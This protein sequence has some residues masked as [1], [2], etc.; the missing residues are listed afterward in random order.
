MAAPRLAGSGGMLPCEN[1]EIW[2][3]GKGISRDLRAAES[4]LTKF[5]RDFERSI[6]LKP[7]DVFPHEIKNLDENPGSEKSCVKQ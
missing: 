4:H 3:L 2:N 7:N 6:F 1:F 5:N